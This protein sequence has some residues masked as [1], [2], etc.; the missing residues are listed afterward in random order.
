MTETQKRLL[1][2]LE[3]AL[4]GSGQ[5]DDRNLVIDSALLEEAHLQ[6]VNT[7]VDSEEREFLQIT[8][9]MLVIA[10]HAE[11]TGILEGIP[12]VTIKGFASARYYPAPA[13]RGMGD[14][15]LYVPSERYNEA[16]D[17]LC[18]AG[19]V[20]VKEDH[21]RHEVFKKNGIV[22]ELHREIKGI[23]DGKDGIRV[24]NAVMEKKVRNYLDDIFLSAVTLETAWGRI[25]VPDDFHHGLTMLLHVAGHMLNDGGV[26]L[27]HLCDW[28]VYVRHVDISQFRTSL[29]DMGLWIFACQMTAVSARYLGISPAGQMHKHIQEGLRQTESGREEAFLEALIEDFLESGNFSCKD[30]NRT[31]GLRFV[32][33]KG[34]LKTMSAMT[35]E[36]F[37]Q[38]EE[39][40]FLMPLAM[41]AY[42]VETAARLITGRRG[43]LNLSDSVASGRKRRELYKEFRLF[44]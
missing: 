6:A 30:R 35:R 1:K 18:H 2:L 10:A 42:G 36:R 31:L 29:Q 14:V 26:G 13:L 33:E 44:E 15:D 19:Y 5:S 39:K 16:A 7:L 43:K 41:T 32:R 17:R 37:P 28:A 21:D 40:P 34:L 27:R 25:V 8:R 20:R 12:F 9:N 38:T 4:S 11:L 23:P 24:E 22:T 3:N